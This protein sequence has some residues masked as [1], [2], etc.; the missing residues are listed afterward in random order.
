[1]MLKV[2]ERIFATNVQQFDYSFECEE[3]L[4]TKVEAARKLE[5]FLQNDELHCFC[6]QEYAKFGYF[7]YKRIMN[8]LWTI[9]FEYPK[10][11]G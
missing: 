3:R 1:M 8:E 4:F 6:N 10:D 2:G 9:K 5:D 11:S 7:E